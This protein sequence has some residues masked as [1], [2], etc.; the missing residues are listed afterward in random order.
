MDLRFPTYMFERLQRLSRNL[1]ILSGDEAPPA[2]LAAGHILGA[3]WRNWIVP[4]SKVLN[5]H[6]STILNLLLTITAV[7]VDL[8]NVSQGAL[9][10]LQKP[11]WHPSGHFP[12][13][14]SDKFRS[15]VQ[16]K[17]C[18]CNANMNWYDALCN[19]FALHGFFR[20]VLAWW[21]GPQRT[22]EYVCASRG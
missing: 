7:Q 19:A 13:W 16:N 8:L 20:G 4:T 17:T 21:G 10:L 3:L 15:L 22:E 18:Y 6:R 11:L 9:A 12:H 5:T 14:V 1:I 2:G